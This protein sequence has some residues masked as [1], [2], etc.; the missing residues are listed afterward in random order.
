MNGGAGDDRMTGGAGNDSLIATG[1]GFDILVF[2]PGFGADTVTGF[3]ANPP[4]GGQDLID[5]TAYNG[6]ATSRDRGS[7]ARTP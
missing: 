6:L 1:A 3:D 2:A 7:L 5:I 4:R